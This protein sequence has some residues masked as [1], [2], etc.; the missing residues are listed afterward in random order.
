MIHL[1]ILKH[2]LYLF[3]INKQNN[4]INNQGNNKVYQPQV[5]KLIKKVKFKK[6]VI[7][8]STKL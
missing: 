3:K 1:E 6:G 2:L 4:G 8:G 7:G 5:D